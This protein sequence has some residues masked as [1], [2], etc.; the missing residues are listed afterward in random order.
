MAKQ[1]TPKENNARAAAALTS[2]P[3]AVVPPQAVELEEAVLGALMLEKD[4]VIEVQGLITPEAFYNEAHQI[5]YKAIVDLSMELKPI[6]LYTVTE[7]LKQIKKLTAV[8]GPSYLAQ[9]TQ[10]VGS[11][12]HVEFHAKIIA[13]KYVQRELIRAT[14]EI[15]KKSFDEATDVT[16]LIDFAE[17]EIFKVAE[18]HVKRDVQK[19]RDILTKTLQMIEEAS[20]REGGFSGVPSGFTHLDRLTLGWQPSDLI[21]IAARPSMGKTA[22]VLSLARN[23]AVD[24]EKGVAFFSLEM[25]AQQL[26]MRLVVAESELDSRSVRNGDLT[27]EQWKHMETAIKPLSTAPLFIDDTP[28]LSIFEFRSKVRRLKTQYDIQLIII[29][30]LQLMTASTD[31]RN[32][33]REQEV[34]MISRSLKAIA[35]ELNVPIIALSQLNRSVES[36][37]GSKRPQLSDLRESGA[38]EQDADLVAF[39]HRPEYYGLT[40]DEDG[41]PTQGMAEIIVAKHRNG[42]V[43]T[44]G[45]SG[46][47]AG[48]MICL[49]GA[50]SF[51]IYLAVFK[52]L[53]ARYSSV[54]LMKWMFLYAAI[55]AIPLC[56][57]DAAAID[58]AHLSPALWGG[59]LYVVCCATFFSYL[60]IPVG[61]KYLRPTVVGMYTYLQPFIASVVAVLAGLDR[62]GFAKGIA[63]VMVCLGVY[64]VNQSKSR[65][66][67]DAE[68]AARQQAASAAQTSPRA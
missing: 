58:Y 62:F 67:L 56:G 54:T 3:M 6:D 60:L 34:A 24:F 57:G 43:D 15:Q 36:R 2:D 50:L 27:P 61:Q 68:R 55:C 44:A 47:I 32:S 19:S 48:D 8:G 12:A 10:K 42:A 5:I 17:G 26:M 28:A 7:K 23:V 64:I 39:I 25:S 21:I 40:V 52:R 53:I 31:N 59:V 35:K 16:D 63:A 37:G 11:A 9:L 66:Q 4:A 1:Y 51:A 38:I 46:S 22:F 41:T 33:N 45:R 65:A 13:Q 14:T 20:K 18:G 49:M 30:Y 29:D